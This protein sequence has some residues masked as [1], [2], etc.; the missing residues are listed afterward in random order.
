MYYTCIF[1]AGENLSPTLL[2]HN[3]GYDDGCFWCPIMNGLNVFLG[4]NYFDQPRAELDNLHSN[5][6]F[7]LGLHNIACTGFFLPW[8]RD[9]YSGHSP[10]GGGG[11][12][13]QI[14]KLGRIK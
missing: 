13:V 6:L 7:R 10:G 14:K 12:F 2:Q 11:I 5:Q 8:S 9:I 3:K 4:Q 1:S